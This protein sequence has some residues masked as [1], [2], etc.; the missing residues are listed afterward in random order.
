MLKKLYY[1]APWHQLVW[2]Y[3]SSLSFTIMCTLT[4]EAGIYF[5]GL[6]EL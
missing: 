2:F 5:E 6:V 1:Y 3:E 4:G